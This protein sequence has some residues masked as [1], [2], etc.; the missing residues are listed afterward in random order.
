M[1]SL[2][3]AGRRAG[4]ARGGQEFRRALEGWRV[5]QHRQAGRA[6][7]LIGARQRRRIEIGTDQPLGR[8]GLLDLGDQRELAA[9]RLACS[10]AR[11]PRGGSASRGRAFSSASGRRALAA[12]ISSRL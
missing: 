7:R 2:R 12:A 6:A 3:S 5:G 1:K 11:K 8:A 10:A 4:G 9:A